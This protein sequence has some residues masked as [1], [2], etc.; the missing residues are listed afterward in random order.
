MNQVFRDYLRK[1]V[2]IFFDDLLVYNTSFLDHAQHLRVVLS[3][4]RDNQ[5]LIKR[6][7]SLANPD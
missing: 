2:L 6:S 4:L 5:L 1:F 7:V 3:L